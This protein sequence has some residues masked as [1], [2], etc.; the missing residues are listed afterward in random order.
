MNNKGTGTVVDLLVFAMLVSIAIT[1]LFIVNPIDPKIESKRYA[2]TFAQSTLL[3]IQHCTADQFGGF[4]Y[5]LSVLDNNLIIPIVEESAKRRLHNKTLANLLVEETLLNMYLEVG[6]TDLTLLRPNRM[7]DD[8][9]RGL[10]KS[11]IDRLI[12]GRFCYRLRVRAEPI[13]LGFARVHFEFEVENLVGAKEQLCSETLMLFLPE[14]G[15]ELTKRLED[16]LGTE[17]PDYFKIDPIAEV[18]LELW[19][20]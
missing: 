11:C 3:S 19:Y 18:A 12:G 1:F 10:L 9:L 5:K 4:E 15:D 8:K 13:K 17:L 2:S 7:M 20:A 14:I 16:A 6:G